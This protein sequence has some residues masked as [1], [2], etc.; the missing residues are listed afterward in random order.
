LR[1]QG[2]NALG[3]PH[4][5]VVSSAG[6]DAVHIA[7]IACSAMIF[8]CCEAG[9]S[10]NEIENAKPVDL[11]AGCLLKFQPNSAYQGCLGRQATRSGQSDFP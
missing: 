4:M 8:V 10:H 1:V 11:A 7:G 2:G 9:I 6:Y 5:D 3:L